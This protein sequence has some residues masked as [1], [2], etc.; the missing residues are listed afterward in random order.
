LMGGGK[1]I[2]RSPGVS[3]NHNGSAALAWK[4]QLR[5]PRPARWELNHHSLASTSFA[6]SG[7]GLE[8]VL[9]ICYR[10]VGTRQE[11]RTR[12]T[13][14]ETYHQQNHGLWKLSGER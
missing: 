14:R 10:V 3:G 7:S 11:R 12:T 5:T 4:L 8:E 9:G 13:K 2:G 6:R 1:L